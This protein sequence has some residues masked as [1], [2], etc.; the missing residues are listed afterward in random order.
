M[1]LGLLYEFNV[2]HPWAGEHPWGQRTAER[3]VYRECIT[4]IVAADKA[5]FK[6][7]WCVEHHFR[8]NRSHMPSNEVV[9]G[10]L[11]QVTKNIQL[12]FGVTLAPHEFIHPARLAEKVATV[13]LLSQGRVQWGIGRSTPMEQIAFGVDQEKSKEKMRAAARS[14]VGMWEQEYYEEH[15]EF[16]DFPKRMVTP[17]PYQYPHPPVWM[18]AVSEGSAEAAG[19]DGLG[20]LCFST[21]TPLGKLKPVIDS[22]R[23]AQASATEDLTSVRTNKVG[24]YTLVHCTDSREK[25]EQSRLWDSMWWWYQGLAEFTLKWEFAH[26][27]DE[28]KK[29]TFP[30]LEKRAKGEFDLTEFDKEDMVIVGTPDECLE[31]LLKYDAMGVDQV[32]CYINF[33]YLPQEA[34]L[35]CIELLGIYVIP[36]LAKRGANR[37]VE[38]LTKSVREA[39]RA[40][41]IG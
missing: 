8:E 3:Q 36:E 22:Y 40:A 31:K 32:L 29:A 5:G 20:L 7:V 9:L 18:A 27:S 6:T 38:G 24:V 37:M 21:L 17:K 28:M 35:R 12:G 16:L 30:L 34:V 26:F 14:V 13:D 2:A 25:F 19:R 10:A 15:S 39:E 1:E 23:S 4:Q 41:A 33:G 11:S